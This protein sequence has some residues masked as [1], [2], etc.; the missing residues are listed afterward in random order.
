VRATAV[1]P[2]TVSNKL[3]SPGEPGEDGEGVVLTTGETADAN[4]QRWYVLGLLTLVYAVN[5]ADR[6]VMSTLIEPIKAELGLSDTRVAL[7]SSS[8]LA[9]FYVFATLP[10]AALADRGNRRNLVAIALAAWSAMTVVCGFT[11]TF[12]QLLLARIGVGIGEAGGTAPSQALLSDYFGWRQ[13]PLALAIY[14]TG[15]SLGAALASTGGWFAEQWGWRSVFFIFGAPGLLLALLVWLTIPEPRRGRLDERPAARVS[16]FRGMLGIALGEPALRHAL[17]ASFLFSFWAWG[18]LLWAPSMLVRS[19]G[20]SLGEAG[21]ILFLIH[22]VGGTAMLLASSAALGPLTRRDARWPAWYGAAAVGLASVPGVLA[23]TTRD[24]A[25]AVPALALFG[26]VMYGVVGPINSLFQNL[27]PAPV[28]AQM[29]AF[30]LLISNL[31][32]MVVAP[33]FIGVVSDWL[34]ERHGAESLRLAL[35]PV[36]LTGF[37]AA[38]HLYAAARGLPAAMRRA[39][40][41]PDPAPASARGA[42]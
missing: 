3:R 6:Y 1:A 37:W 26:V 34:Y 13:R 20:M 18:I 7:L 25:L 14:A 17:A 29:A 28:R 9:L 32:Y 10:L 2:S 42:G 16:G 11:R 40:N 4:W 24:V 5:I 27:A 33:Q 31:A 38:W 36:A 23:V 39:G 41:D 8:A 22:G 12:W 35:L 15:V 21:R 30:A 19:H